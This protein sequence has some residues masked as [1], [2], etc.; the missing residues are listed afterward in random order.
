MRLGQE[1]D[2]QDRKWRQM[3]SQDGFRAWETLGCVYKSIGRAQLRERLNR[4]KGRD[5][6]PGDL[7]GRGQGP[8]AEVHTVYPVKEEGWS[9]AERSGGEG[10]MRR[11]GKF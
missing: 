4:Q 7:L 11:Q 5:E 8:N 9:P 3:C 10:S 1:T 6:G 2:W